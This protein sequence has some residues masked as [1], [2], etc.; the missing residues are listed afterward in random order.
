VVYDVTDRTSFE[1]VRNWL[2]EID[3]YTDQRTHKYIV[4]NKCD[5]EEKRQVTL[6]EAE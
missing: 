5:L 6:E 3:K 4:G 2:E 1:N